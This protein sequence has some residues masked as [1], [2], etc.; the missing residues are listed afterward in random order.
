MSPTVRKG[1]EKTSSSFRPGSS[2]MLHHPRAYVP[3]SIPSDVNCIANSRPTAHP[4]GASQSSESSSLL[5]AIL[6]C[7]ARGVNHALHAIFEHQFPEPG[8]QAAS[9]IE[10]LHDSTPRLNAQIERPY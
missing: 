9:W 8:N 7:H 5:P 3:T 4:D 2:R 1:L 10:K 6:V